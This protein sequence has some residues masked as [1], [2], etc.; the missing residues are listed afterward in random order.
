MIEGLEAKIAERKASAPGLD[1]QLKAKE[2]SITSVKPT[3]DEIN[4]I[5]FSFG[6]TSFKLAVAGERGDMYRIVRLDG[7]DAAKTLSEGERSFITFLY[8]YHMLAGST[9]G[10]GSTV[11]KVAVFD[12][13]VSSLDVWSRNLMVRI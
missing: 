7:S 13:P 2:A 5:L 1:A 12:D 11:E 9:S 4:R 6:F 8:F 10:T 3:I